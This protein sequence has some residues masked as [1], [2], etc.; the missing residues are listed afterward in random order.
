VLFIVWKIKVW[1]KV[2]EHL[3]RKNSSSSIHGDSKM[4]ELPSIPE[5]YRNKNVFVTGG[6]GFIGKVL[7]EKLLRSCPDIQG[8]ILL[9]RDKKRRSF[10]E[11]LHSITDSPVSYHVSPKGS[12]V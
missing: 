12:V 7:I 4:A 11:R 6:S 2:S 5:F 10:D 9:M 8:V 3:R 1:V